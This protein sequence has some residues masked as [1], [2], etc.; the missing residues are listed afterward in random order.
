MD[1]LAQLEGSGETQNQQ[2]ALAGQGRPSV[3]KGGVAGR[4][5]GKGFRG[6][7]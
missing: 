1:L 3:H 7:G 2:E 4:I 6:S 5:L